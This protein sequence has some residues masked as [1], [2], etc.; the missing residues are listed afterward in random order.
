MDFQQAETKVQNLRKKIDY[1]IHRYYVLDDP[2]IEDHEFDRLMNELKILETQ[3]PQLV[4]EESPTM[5]VGGTVSSTFEKVAH[6]VQ[7]GS[8]QDVFDERGIIDFC[9]RVADK[10]GKALYIV[11]PKVDGLSVS[12]TYERGIF[13]RGATRG[14]GYTGED[15]TENLRTI[16][17]VPLKLTRPVE[18]LEVRGEVYMSDDD[19][20]ELR[21][22]QEIAGGTVFKNP[23]NAAAGSLRQK[24]SSVTAQRKLDIFV[25]NIQSAQG[26][27]LHSHKQSLELLCELG[28]KVV[29][30][31]KVCA[32]A[33]DIIAEIRRIGANRFDGYG[34][35]IDGAVVKADDFNQRN[36]L[37]ATGKYPRWAVAYKYPPEE[38]ETLLADIKINVGRTGALTPVAVFEPVLLAGTTVS[39]AVLHNQ[40]FIEQKDVRIGDRIL[41]RK[42]GD[43]IPEVVRSISHKPNS[44]AYIMPDKCPVCDGKASKSGSQASLRCENTLCPAQRLRGIIHFASRSAMNIEG[45]GEAVISLLAEKEII[46][47]AADLYYIKSEQLTG[48]DRFAQKSAENLIESIDKSKANPLYRFIFALGIREIGESAA[49]LLAGHFGDIDRLMAATEEEIAQIEGFGNIMAKNAVEFFRIEQNREMIRKFKNA[50]VNMGTKTASGHTG[51]AGGTSYAF[52]GMT[53]VITGTL[54][55]YTREQAKEIIEKNGGSV[56]S[57]V[58]S[59]T[60]YVLAGENA[61]N[62]LKKAQELGIKIINQAEFQQMAGSISP[63]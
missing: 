31:Y 44:A 48:L 29:P 41:V 59:K 61:G 14:D 45:L 36:E 12:L 50:Q 47:D 51:I 40:S 17:S 3:Y 33:N 10:V 22:N 8:L 56:S 16:R 53:F 28:F 34:F 32:N 43:I 25:F 57:S 2:E 54:P 27:E 58:S 19:F 38:K 26:L 7:M 4:T 30:F 52:N 60:S 6:S 49:K 21:K 42:A 15:V 35:G 20:Y 1:H 62:K 63:I 46:N 9:D 11:E 55:D 5:R 24:D 18:F 23:R 37:G 13:Q 39:R